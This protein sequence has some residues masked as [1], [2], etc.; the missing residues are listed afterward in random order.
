MIKE[1]ILQRGVI[2]KCFK[3]KTFE[4][5]LQDNPEHRSLVTPSGKLLKNQI[6]LKTGDEVTIELSPYDL[7]RGRIIWRY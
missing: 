4:V 2:T 3:G 5:T 7:H 1:K 6:T